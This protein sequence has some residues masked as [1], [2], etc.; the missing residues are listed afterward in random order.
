VYVTTSKSNLPSEHADQETQ[1][2]LHKEAAWET[3]DLETRQ[4]LYA[5][6]PASIAGEMPHDPSVNPLQSQFGKAIENELRKWQDDLKEGRETRKWREE[7]MLAGRDRTSG[8]LD[9]AEQ[10]GGRESG[11]DSKAM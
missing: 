6:L 10:A 3:L 2:I 7:A 4:R 9:V 1:Q 8:S 5:L 11:E